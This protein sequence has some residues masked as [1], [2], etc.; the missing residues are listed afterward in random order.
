MQ[1]KNVKIIFVILAL[2]VVLTACSQTDEV[3]KCNSCGENISMDAKFCSNCGE[4]IDIG[5]EDSTQKEPETGCSHIWDDATCSAPKTCQKCGLTEG[6]FGDHN[7]KNATCTTPKTCL[8]CNTA[9]GTVA[10]KWDDATCAKPKTCS[11]CRITEGDAL[12]HTGEEECSRCGY[13]DKSVAI[14][15][16]KNTVHVYGIDLDMDSAGGVDTYITWENVSQKEIKYIVF[17]VQYYN[18]V[19]DILKD[20][21]DDSTT[22]RLK[23]TGP[24]P[25]G[26]GCYDVIAISGGYGA[27]SYYFTVS[28]EEY[29][30]DKENGWAN[31]YWEAPFYNTT[32]KYAKLTKIEIEYMDG[33]YY[34]ISDPE[35][36]ASVV[37][38]GEH[39]NAYS[40]DDTG[41]D[42][43]R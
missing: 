34:T 10:H 16:A 6:T 21:I 12:G 35:A 39:P 11:E 29:D 5:K 18:R 43:L 8:I 19:K 20:E 26:K 28:Y 7:W 13:I 30:I 37:G 40:T 33:T 3:H 17:S 25:H 38:N 42:Y 36:I 4:Q 15:N 23:Q 31:T 14:Q 32:A 9:E 2:V 22:V 1:T 41:D 27:R 24:I